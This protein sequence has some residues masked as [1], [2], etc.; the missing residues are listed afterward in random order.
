MTRNLDQETYGFFGVLMSLMVIL[1]VPAT[2]GYQIS[3]VR[4]AGQASSNKNIDRFSDDLWA[5]FLTT[6]AAGIFVSCLFYWSSGYF[7]PSLDGEMVNA[8][9]VWLA[10]LLLLLMSLNVLFSEALRGLGWIGWAA[11]LTGL[12][13]HGGAVRVTIM[14]LAS[15][16]VVSVDHFTLVSL[17]QIAVF[18]SFVVTSVAVLALANKM[19]LTIR[20]EGIIS[21]LKKNVGTNMQL[22]S[23]QLLQLLSGQYAAIVIGGIFFG[24]TS[25][26]LL[27]A[28][29]QLRVLLSA[30][31]TLINGAI[32]A[33]LI[34][35][36]IRG[37]HAEL[38]HLL[39]LSGSMATAVSLA[40]L[41][42][43][44]IGGSSLFSAIFG[45]SY[46]DA[47]LFFLAFAPGLLFNAFCGSAAKALTLLGHER[48]FLIVTALT[49]IIAV[50]AF[51]LTAQVMGP[52]GLAVALSIILV[53]QNLA[54]LILLH[55]KIGV[56][57]HAYL[58]PAQYL[59]SFRDLGRWAQELRKM[60]SDK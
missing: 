53:F 39:R 60:R 35:A 48:I 33:L 51:Y 7:L 19:S 29:Q 57:S 37:N 40:A 6:L 12:G 5:A 9:V 38:T 24:G 22:M 44:A 46:G 49:S 47:F 15:L 36:H 8:Q 4:L 14:L 26:A 11:S 43:V 13:Q 25:L 34:D 42:M 16:L 23:G 31:I 50:P 1:V 20:V 30:P 54:F 58:H 18:G 2:A 28:A 55:E 27:F 52:I 56:W 3:I 10:V 45:P 21:S 32:P 59:E 41:L 17:L